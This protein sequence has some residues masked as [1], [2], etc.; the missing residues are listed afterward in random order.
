MPHLNSCWRL[1]TASSSPNTTTVMMLINFSSFFSS[2]PVSCSCWTFTLYDFFFSFFF[3]RVVCFLFLCVYSRHRQRQHQPQ[4]DHRRRRQRRQRL[5][6][7]WTTTITGIKFSRLL[8]ASKHETFKRP[9]THHLMFN[10][11]TAQ[12][13]RFRFTTIS[14]PTYREISLW[15]NTTIL[16]Q[17]RVLLI[18]RVLFWF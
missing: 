14:M 18:F 6:D 12:I 3:F 7:L 9:L 15:F 8:T 16:Q 5:A 11:Y 2:V 1:S 10:C 4:Q 17:V 13:I